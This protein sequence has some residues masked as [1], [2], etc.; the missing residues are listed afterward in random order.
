MATIT[1][2]DRFR[3]TLTWA[4]GHAMQRKPV[5]ADGGARA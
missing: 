4:D 2:C 3:E 1:R 5:E